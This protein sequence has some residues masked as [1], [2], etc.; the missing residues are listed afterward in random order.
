MAT[1]GARGAAGGAR[2]ANGSVVVIGGGGGGEQSLSEHIAALE[3]LD[4][5]C[6]LGGNMHLSN[7]RA[8]SS[9]PAATR[10]GLRRFAA[11]DE[12]RSPPREQPRVLRYSRYVIERV[13]HRIDA[14]FA[15]LKLRI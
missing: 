5:L 10:A 8:A 12:V 6:A 2:G 3:G 11:A 15:L 9:F 1:A 7:P 14:R 13:S 4:A